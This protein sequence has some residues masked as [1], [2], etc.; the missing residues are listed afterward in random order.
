M[1]RFL[2]IEAEQALLSLFLEVLGGSSR[3]AN[4]EEADNK[5]VDSKAAYN[6]DTGSEK[7]VSKKVYRFSVDF[8][9]CI[10]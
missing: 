1:A 5:V 6:K 9:L 7:A 8:A 2:K 10:F 4:G 3:E